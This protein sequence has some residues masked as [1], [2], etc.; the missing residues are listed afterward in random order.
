MSKGSI[1]LS[2]ALQQYILDTSVRESD[3]L[4][5]LRQET[6]KLPRAGMQIAPEQGQLL[7]LL[8]QLIAA[9]RVLEIGVFT[10]YSSL[11][12]AEAIP[13]GGKLVACDHNEEWTEIARRYWRDAGV[14]DRIDLRLGPALETLQELTDGGE[15]GSY[16]LIFID[17]DKT[18]YLNYFE[19][20]LQL[21]RAGGLIVIDN[22]LWSGSVIDDKDNSPDTVAIR[23]FNRSLYED[24]RIDLSLIPIGDGLT[25]ARKR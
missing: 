21:V 13:P 17:A 9:R 2:T 19:L 12:M 24:P 25:L 8:L 7:K 11:C 20:S 23:E 3:L 16:D 15:M 6:A 4:A 1:G 5:R 10:G 18:N 22:V 14:L